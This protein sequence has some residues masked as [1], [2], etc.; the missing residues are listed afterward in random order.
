MKER[1]PR[2]LTYAM[3]IAELIVDSEDSKENLLEEK[4][5]ALRESLTLL[6]RRRPG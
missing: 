6:W 2:M 5:K 3:A 1:N 4:F